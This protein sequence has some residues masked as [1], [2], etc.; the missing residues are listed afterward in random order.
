VDDLLKGG[1][2]ALGDT[3]EVRV[4]A[5]GSVVYRLR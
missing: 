1:Q 4:A 3:I 5:H 2:L